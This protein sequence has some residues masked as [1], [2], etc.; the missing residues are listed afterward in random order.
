MKLFVL[1][2]CVLAISMVAATTSH[3]QGRH[4]TGANR[5]YQR[6]QG[7]QHRRD[8][9]Q[10][11]RRPKMATEPANAHQAKFLSLKHSIDSALAKRKTKTRDMDDLLAELEAKRD[12]QNQREQAD[13][14]EDQMQ[15]MDVQDIFHEGQQQ[16]IAENS[17]YIAAISQAQQDDIR[18]EVAEQAEAAFEALGIGADY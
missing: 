18:K 15:M 4:R 10:F 7:V 9:G 14:V 8:P 1:L 12:A 2:L 17:A 5:Q 3:R 16:L 11:Q 13:F 6:R